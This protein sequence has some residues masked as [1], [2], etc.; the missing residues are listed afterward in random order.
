M[1]ERNDFPRYFGNL[2]RPTSYPLNMFAACPISSH[3]GALQVCVKCS[4]MWETHTRTC[5]HTHTY[6]HSNKGRWTSECFSSSSSPGFLKGAR[7][8]H[9]NTAVL[10]MYHLYLMF[11]IAGLN[12]NDNYHHWLQ[13][14]GSMMKGKMPGNH[15]YFQNP[16]NVL[17]SWAVQASFATLAPDQLL[18]AIPL[19]DI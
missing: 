19:I 4:R 16:S 11:M 10:A 17:F 6:T 1:R 9:L 12:K 18:T 2:L 14:L 8:N 5:T 13:M 7:W 3:P 15:V